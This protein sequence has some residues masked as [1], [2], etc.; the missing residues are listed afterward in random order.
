MCKD[1]QGIKISDGYHSGWEVYWI[2]GLKA[3]QM[4]GLNY[5]GIIITE[6]Y[7]TIILTH[8]VPSWY[9]IYN[10]ESLETNMKWYC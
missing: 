3:Y 1:Y 5:Q 9:A 6:H 4:R 2:R 7:Q 10:L 8:D